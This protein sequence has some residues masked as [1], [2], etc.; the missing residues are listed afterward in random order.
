M[1]YDSKPIACFRLQPKSDLHPAL[2]LYDLAS[3]PFELI[4]T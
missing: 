2:S 4:M 3:T 1:K